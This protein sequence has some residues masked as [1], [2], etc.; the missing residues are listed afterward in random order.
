MEILVNGAPTQVAPGTTVS[1]LLEQLK[2]NPLYVAVECN[3]NLI[4][5][6]QHSDCELQ[7]QD[8]IEIVT[9]VGGG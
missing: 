6:A 4:P 8:S 9:L 3:L 1:G 7:P 5:R 2:M